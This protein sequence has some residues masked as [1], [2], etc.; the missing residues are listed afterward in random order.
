[1]PPRPPWQALTVAGTYAVAGL[2]WIVGSDALLAYAAPAEWLPTLQALKGMAFILATA[3][4]LYVLL[5]RLARYQA[6]VSEQVREKAALRGRQEAFES[7]AEHAPD[8]IARF[9]RGLRYTYVN[10]RVSE[11]A[12][13]PRADFLGRTHAELGYEPALVALWDN[14]LEQARDQ[15]E[16]QQLTFRMSGSSGRQRF[17]EARLVPE[18]GEAGGPAESV[19]AITRDLTEL[20]ESQQRVEQLSVLY[21]ALSAANQMIMRAADRYELFES[22]CRILTDQSGLEMAW[23][24]L[25]EPQTQWVAPRAWAGGERAE[26]YL[27]RCRV[28]ADPRRPEGQGPVGRALQAEAT[29]VFDDFLGAP[30]AVPWQGAAR[31]LGYSAVAACPLQAGG[32]VIGAL[33]VYAGRTDFFSDEVV[34]LIEEL[35]GDVGYALDRFELEE[36]TRYLAAHDLVTGLP[37]RAQ[38]LDRLEQALTRWRR[39]GGRLAVLFLD[40]DRFKGVNDAFGHEVGDQLLQEV[41]QRLLGV[42]REMDTVCRQ[43]GDEFLLLLPEI[44][45]A[46]DAAQVAEKV[47]AALASP[48]C[49][50]GT[51]L[52]VT[53]SIGISLC[54]EDGVEADTL[55]RNADT[56]MYSAKH[57]GRNR[58]C[59]F[60]EPMNRRVQQRLE[61]ESGLRDA[62]RRGELELGYQPQVDIASGAVVG[63]EALVR[64]RHP[65]H[66]LI[67]PANFIPVAEESGQIARIGDWVLAEACR[68]CAAWRETALAG[69]PVAV[70]LSAA[71]LGRS[72]LAEGILRHLEAYGLPSSALQLEMTEGLFFHET[73]PVRSTLQS[74][75]RS[76]LQLVVDD[77]GTGYS[78]LGYLKR[79]P[80]AKLKI[81]ESFVRGLPEDT[82]DVVISSTLIRMAHGLRLRVIAEGVE[83]AEQLAFLREHGC[84]EAQG[85][86]F[87][88]PLAGADLARWA[89]RR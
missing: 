33:A 20:Q 68:Q 72:D 88:R 16:M 74:L 89:Q 36:R 56:A 50:A 85:F 39:F 49:L 87:S 71:Q 64:W 24:G 57:G 17:Y 77:F 22:V 67:S 43:G 35:A 60:T 84:D 3:G 63:V 76:G 52:V 11:A 7:L 66:G 42:T 26:R 31:E 51:E 83:T 54:P 41:A 23:I 9:D 25:I 6:E 75:Q 12:G 69:L 73:E 53:P 8:L 47:V 65:R 2:L 32:E 19:L 82:E 61:M 55:V 80:V 46:E 34:R 44:D 78:N 28:S 4:L 18:G 29:V 79:F 58:Y 15:G 37:N 13:R 1:M 10:P 59:F 86:Y 45:S 62:E 48:F 40:L 30:E 27:E 14:H 70:N 5:R 21:A 38:M 81:D